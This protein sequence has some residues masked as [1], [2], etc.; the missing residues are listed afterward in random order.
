MNF[1]SP[2]YLTP[3]LVILLLAAFA[4]G[5]SL[6]EPSGTSDPVI[7]FAA[8]ST[9]NAMTDIIDVYTEHHQRK[10]VT[11]FASSSS[12][13]KQIDNGAPAHIY[14]SANIKWMNYLEQK[15]LIAPGSRIDLLGNRIVLIAPRDSAVR[16]IDV[17]PGFPLN[18]ALGDGRLAMGDPDHVPAG[19]YG[20]QAFQSLG[21]WDQ[22]KAKL[23]PMKDVRAALALVERGEVPL[24]Q[25]YATDAA[26]SKKVRVVGTFPMDSHPPIVYPLAV[27][28]GQGNPDVERFMDFLRSPQ[29]T[30]IF[31]RYGF[32]VR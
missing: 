12:L 22:V 8:A 4:P 16:K 20:K 29:S 18:E 27:I 6:A 7:V 5:W 11:S 1:I 31:K 9:T 14:L 28:A 2:K 3:F 21:V 32:E 23:A 10:V 17:K 24:G 30:D 19:I 25:V 15:H 13:A 26:I